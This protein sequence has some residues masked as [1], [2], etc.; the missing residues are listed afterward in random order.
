[1]E[2]A[3][4]LLDDEGKVATWYSGARRM[5]GYTAAEIAGQPLSLL[6]AEAENLHAREELGRA[7][8]SG[9]TGAEGW[10][11]RKDGSKFWGNAIT[12]ALHDDQGTL[13]GFA[14][15]VR[16]FSDRHAKAEALQQTAAAR[17][18]AGMPVLK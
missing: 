11:T 17:F 16:D 5:Y 1:M 15:L 6:H 10:H 13:Q 12:L 8:G 14:R 9:H 2:C 7:S 18:S 4:F 3:L